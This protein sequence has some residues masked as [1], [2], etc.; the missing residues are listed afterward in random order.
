[1]EIIK[2]YRLRIYPNKREEQRLIQVCDSVRFIWNYYLNKR[3]NEFLENGRDIS[4]YDCCKHLTRLK[5]DPGYEWLNKAKAQAL[6]Q[7]LRDLDRTYNS[8]LKN[9]SNFPHFKSR[10]ESK[11][12][13]RLPANWRF[14]DGKILLTH[15]LIIKFRGTVIP[16]HAILKS[17]TIFRDTDGKWYVSVVSHEESSFDSKTGEPI[18]IDLGLSHLA[19]TS[20][21]KKYD[22]YRPKKLLKK[23]M[24]KLQQDLSRKE[25]GSN[26]RSKAKQNL[27]VLHKKIR[28]QRMNYLHQTSHRITSEN[29][30]LIVCEDLAVKNMVKNHK[31][32]DAISESGWAEF[33]RQL[34]YKQMWRGGQ[35][36]KIDRF[37]PSSK[38]CSS[39]NFIVEKLPL[40]VR[41][42]TCPSC[43]SGHDRDINAAK[44]ILAQ[45]LSNS[46]EWRVQRVSPATG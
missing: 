31:L 27:A 45:G 2:R 9:K 16:K 14:K 33:V 17:I 40:S 43:G 6:Q 12:S 26:S 25:K 4:Y 13:F 41:R 24:K 15:D 11:L 39:C 20:D 28:S 35:F 44:M 22:T 21:G 3:K 1:M 34:E 19:I 46:P 7:S 38:T 42:W 10:K 29:Q 36:T 23:R 30:A 37:F 18:G 32:A 8:F 5:K